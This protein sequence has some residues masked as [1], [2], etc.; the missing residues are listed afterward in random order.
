MVHLSD[1]GTGSERVEEL[2]CASAG[3]EAVVSTVTHRTILHFAVMVC[4]YDYDYMIV[5][6]A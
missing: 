3:V 4:V 6:R 5:N 2:L 1:E